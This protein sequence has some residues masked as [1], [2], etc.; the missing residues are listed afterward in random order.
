M[1]AGS[2][3]TRPAR[4]VLWRGGILETYE[5]LRFFMNVQK[6][7]LACYQNKVAEIRGET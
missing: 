5:H 6:F 7:P 1:G 3:M 4:P 2:G